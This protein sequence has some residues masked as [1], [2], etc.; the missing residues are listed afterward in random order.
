MSK[1]WNLMKDFLKKKLSK[2]RANFPGSLKM[3]RDGRE[4]IFE[5]FLKKQAEDKLDLL[6][7]SAKG[8]Q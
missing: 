8:M 6:F 1:N 7:Q 3:E 5:S 2:D 4:N